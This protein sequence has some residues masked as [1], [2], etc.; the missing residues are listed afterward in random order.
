MYVLPNVIDK[1]I[2]PIRTMKMR[3][4]GHVARMGG[5]VNTHR[6]LVGKLQNDQLEDLGL[7]WGCEGVDWIDLAQDTDKW[8]VLEKTAMDLRFA[9]SV[10]NSFTS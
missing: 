8:G 6:V 3:W 5:N 9:H 4:A 2:T 10:G 1:L 7:D